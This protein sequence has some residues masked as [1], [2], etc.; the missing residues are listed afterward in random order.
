MEILGGSEGW[1]SGVGG[2]EWSQSV[3]CHIGQ[4]N[5]MASWKRSLSFI[6][7]GV[8]YIYIATELNGRRNSVDHYEDYF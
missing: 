3:Y 1:Q 4:L 5:E 6:A 8:T 2:A 7:T